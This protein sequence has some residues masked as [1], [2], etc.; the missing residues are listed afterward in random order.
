[1]QETHTRNY[2]CADVLE[3]GYGKENDSI[4]QLVKE[5]FP[6]L[7]IVEQQ[8]KVEEAK[9]IMEEF[10]MGSETWSVTTFKIFHGCKS[11]SEELNQ[12]MEQFKHSN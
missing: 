9:R 7:S 2:E 1:M 6:N 5:W 8:Q 3:S 10:N 4:E 11:D 12:K